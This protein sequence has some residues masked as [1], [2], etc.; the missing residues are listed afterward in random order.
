MKRKQIDV[1]NTSI[2]IGSIPSPLGQNNKPNL[3]GRKTGNSLP[4][5]EVRS[6]SNS[7]GDLCAAFHFFP[8]PLVLSSKSYICPFSLMVQQ[9]KHG[10]GCS[11]WDPLSLNDFIPLQTSRGL[12]AGDC[13]GNLTV[14]DYCK[15]DLAVL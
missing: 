4:S 14:R 12:E 5:S 8:Q 9:G 1:I 15:P 11:P 6:M 7:S 13:C 2:W 3:L 10:Q